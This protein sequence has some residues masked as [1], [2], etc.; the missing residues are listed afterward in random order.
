MVFAK[1]VGLFEYATFQTGN[2]PQDTL[3]LSARP[4]H[5]AAIVPRVGMGPRESGQMSLVGI[6]VCNLSALHVFGAK[7]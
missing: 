1:V 3:F 7:L 6:A 4:P 2:P 5:H